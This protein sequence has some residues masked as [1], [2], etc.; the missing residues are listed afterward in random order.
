M[1]PRH[2]VLLSDG[3]GNSAGKIS[4]TNVWRIFET[5]DLSGKDQLAFYDDGVGTGGFQLF[6]MLGGAFG[7]GLARN[8]R[9]LYEDLC[10]HYRSDG[11]RIFLF[12]FSRGAFTIRIVSSLIEHCGVID[13]G[14]DKTIKIW[15]WRSFRSEEVPVAT[16]AGLKAAVW[17]AYRAYRKRHKRGI[18]AKIYR[19]I[20][21]RFLKTPTTEEFNAAYSVSP[22]PRI[23]FVGVF[24]TVSAYGLP[25]DELTIF[26]HK[27][28]FPLRFPNM[29]LSQKVD[30][31][32]QALAL[33]E[34]RQ[35]FHPV[36]WTERKFVRGGEGGPDPRPHQVWFPGVHAD[37]GGGYSNER[38]SLVPAL[39]MLNE[40]RKR[41]GLRL[42]QSA[43]ADLI[44]R[45]SE[46]GEIHDSRRGLCSVLSL[47]TAFS[48]AA[49]QSGSGQ[50]QLRRGA[51]RPV[52]NTPVG[53]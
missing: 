34:A 8:V 3:T 52:Q 21:D 38:L 19:P 28:L 45:A 40:A 24:D 33:D 30:A 10:R 20:R 6:R 49:R 51:G 9:Q 36:L 12:G 35:S 46:F 16:D 29:I 53:V 25:V 42:R 13:R 1:D 18:V 4:K 14:Q 32:V 17:I 43:M 31:A 48:G 11:D 27:Y 7:F 47:Q 2:I 22:R 41:A 44:E 23:A 26:I 37:I 15:N 50:E 39:W 5:I